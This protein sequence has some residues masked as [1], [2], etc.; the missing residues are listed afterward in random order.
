[1]AFILSLLNPIYV[2]L[3]EGQH[4]LVLLISLL[5]VYIM[6]AGK[7]SGP[8]ES[9]QVM[10]AGLAFAA[11]AHLEFVGAAPLYRYDAW[12]CALAILILGVQFPVIA[13][14][15]LEPRSPSG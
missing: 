9:R 4:V 8:R 10:G 3:R 1:M 13:P 7:G 5:V 14:R 11:L 6:A 15:G 12:W 2:C